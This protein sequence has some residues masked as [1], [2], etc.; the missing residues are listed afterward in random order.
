MWAASKPRATESIFCEIRMK[1]ISELLQLSD[2][3]S[4]NRLGELLHSVSFYIPACER[5]QREKQTKESDKQNRKMM[6]CWCE[7]VSVAH[8][9]DIHIERFYVT[10]C[11]WQYPL[12]P[13]RSPILGS[14]R[15]VPHTRYSYST[16]IF[17]AIGKQQF[18]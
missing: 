16:H 7:R 2:Y 4:K 10:L 15:C 5:Y 8:T 6:A 13:I 1:N 14:V 18:G 12:L 11:M 9:C 3:R 17:P